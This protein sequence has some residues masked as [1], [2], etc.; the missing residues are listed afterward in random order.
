MYFHPVSR[1]FC[2]KEKP[3]PAPRGREWCQQQVKPRSPALKE[4]MARVVVEELVSPP[5]TRPGFN[6]CPPGQNCCE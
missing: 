5:R 6:R 1:K 4:A 2:K 3:P